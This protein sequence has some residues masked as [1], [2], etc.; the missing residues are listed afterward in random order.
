MKALVLG[1]AE[2][3]YRDREDVSWAQF[4]RTYGA[5][6]AGIICP[7]LDVWVIGHP[8]DGSKFQRMFKAWGR[9]LPQVVMGLHRQDKL[10][11]TAHVDRWEDPRFPDCEAK[12]FDSGLFSTR[13]AIKDGATKVILC[14]V[15]LS[16]GSNLNG[17]TPPMHSYAPY[18][19]AWEE[20]FPHLEGRVKSCSGF[21]RDLLGA[22]TREWWNEP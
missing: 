16:V 19:K 22:P 8:E 10:D 2:C 4:E 5:N 7:D 13:V 15:P 9:D 6:F 17:W 1:S 14:G 18:R 20:A 12:R 11:V 21:T 3:V